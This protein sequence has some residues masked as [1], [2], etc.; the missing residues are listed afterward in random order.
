MTMLTQHPAQ[1]PRSTGELLRL[2]A[3][4]EHRA[5]MRYRTLSETMRRRGE[6][7]LAR[8]FAFLAALEEKHTKQIAAHGP[9]PPAADAAAIAG[10]GL[11]D[12]FDDEA[13]ASAS[14]TPY[15]AL[16]LAV[17]NE[18]SCFALYSYIAA[19][20]ASAE[21]RRLAEALA[22]DELEHAALLRR[23]RRRAYRAERA[24][25]PPEPMPENVAALRAF[26]GRQAAVAAALHHALAAL[27]A[28][29]GQTVAADAFAA[30]AADEEIEADGVSPVP[31]GIPVTVTT[32]LR[33]LE[34]AFD[35]YNAIVEHAAS[36]AVLGEAQRLSERALRRLTLARGRLATAPE[37]TLPI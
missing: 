37:A 22:K 6:G 19:T 16:A 4:L 18:E 15:R 30:V 25:W 24:L 1:Q 9:V 3:R 31:P 27:L 5:A 12:R 7:D 14:L 10:T 29:R 28:E 13:A 34:E 11:P 35:R 26:A 36:E 17:R 2:A 8:L 20:A 32:G 33:L 21:V 23:K